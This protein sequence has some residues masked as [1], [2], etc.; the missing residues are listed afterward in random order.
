MTDIGEKDATSDLV[1]AP[2][3]PECVGAVARVRLADEVPG[4]A[5]AAANS[6]TAVA[7]ATKT[8]AAAIGAGRWCRRPASSFDGVRTFDP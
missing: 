4:C 8:V 1:P 7:S 6:A 3:P 5:V 2:D